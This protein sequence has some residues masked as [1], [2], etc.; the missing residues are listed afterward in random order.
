M[1]AGTT[2]G[3]RY[4]Q[5]HTEQSAGA[6]AESP[7]S[8]GLC[9]PCQGG[10]LPCSLLKVCSF[11][12]LISNFICRVLLLT[13]AGYTNGRHS[14]NER[15]HVLTKMLQTLSEGFRITK[16]GFTAYLIVVGKIAGPMQDRARSDDKMPGLQSRAWLHC[17]ACWKVVAGTP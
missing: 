3:G 6:C 11:V 16:A 17:R 13:A 7:Q 4:G 15:L 10:T 1:G 8:W 2:A 14:G 9:Q 12:W 5:H